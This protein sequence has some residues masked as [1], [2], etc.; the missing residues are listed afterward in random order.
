MAGAGRLR[1]QLGQRI[2]HLRK[3]KGWTQQDAARKAN[4]DYKYLGAIERGERNI[5]VDNIEKIAAGLGVEAHQ[6]FLFSGAKDE[7]PE[8]RVTEAKI[9]DLLKHSGPGRRQLMWRVL[10]EL[11]VGEEA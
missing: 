8:E 11:A 6:L 4:L 9:R 2:R 7:L 5:T 3:A 1:H 10:R